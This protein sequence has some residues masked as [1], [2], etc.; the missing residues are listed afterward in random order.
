VPASGAFVSVA[1]PTTTGDRRPAPFRLGH[2]P[3]LDGVR[4]IAVLL[5]L[6][7]HTGGLLWWDARYWLAPGGVLGLD[8]FFVLSGFLITSLLLGE[9]D[10]HGRVRLGAFA[11]RRL[12]R[13]VPAVV[14]VFAFLLAL[15]S[16]G[17]F[18]DLGE[19]LR[20]AP[21]LFTFSHNWAVAEGSAVQLNHLWSV[22]LEGQF[23]LVWALAVAWA[24]RAGSP[25]RAL[26]IVAGAGVAAV[27][28]GRGLVY[29]HLPLADL[30]MGTLWRF[31]AP[32]IGC[33]AGMA[34]S[35]GWLPW[36]QGRVAARAGLAVLALLAVGVVV[37]ESTDAGLYR[38]GYTV[39]A[40][41]AGV[42]VLAAVRVP[43]SP[44]GRVLA[45]RPLALAGIVSYSLYVW[46][47]PVYEILAKN[48]TDW[49]P[50]ARVVVGLALAVG[51]AVVSY[52][53]VERPFLRRRP[54]AAVAG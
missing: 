7:Y 8:I 14:A 31:D 1:A 49:P 19:V 10:G 16:A 33:L 53:F 27:L 3:Q 35:A 51:A 22:A 23:Y 50:L 52:R 45:L 2:R 34:A 15:A 5:V 42:L 4:G 18:Y 54:R 28:V 32:L 11:G 26:A 47:V 39:V 9:V 40:L 36:F 13:L 43:S 41:C 25:H 21:T 37:L 24:A 17:K 30:Y 12:R 6:T 20:S 48:T 44:L 46:H 38:G 29:G